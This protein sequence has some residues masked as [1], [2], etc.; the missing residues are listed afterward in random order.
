MALPKPS[1]NTTVA[2][3]GASS[4]IG[5][6]LARVLTARGHSVTLIARRK[7]RLER[8]AKDLESA[9]SV[10]VRV[11]PADLAEPSERKN[12]ADELAGGPTLVGLCNNAGFGTF[13]PVDSC[14][15]DQER[16]M[17]QVNIA[18]LHDL[19]TRLV[20]G[21]VERGRGAILNTASTAGFQPLPYM[22][23]YAAT[24][25]FVLSFSEA[26][27]AELSGTGVS[28]TA[29]CPGPVKTEFAEV[30]GSAG[31]EESM[32]G[33]AMVDAS[34]VARHAVDGMS[35]GRRIV[36]PGIANA[37]TAYAGRLAP[38]SLVLPI[39]ARFTKR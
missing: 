13:A 31:L 29:L 16:K 30:A 35:K 18:A 27:N 4:G 15:G 2:I 26:L 34:D 9:H 7:D 28:C 12:L 8:I 24:K 37:A 39:A 33:I 19:T 10:D 23:T 1:E 22:A 3:T 38:R 25:A 5:E 11:L 21:M 20:G 17:I 36:I 14:D 32:P 6:E